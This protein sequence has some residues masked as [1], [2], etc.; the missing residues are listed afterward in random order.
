L[1]LGI[2]SYTWPWAVESYQQQKQG[3]IY[4]LKI[5]KQAALHDI[6]FVQLCDNLPLHEL[7]AQERDMLKR[8][9]DENHIVIQ[10]GTKR[11]TSDNLDR[12]ISIAVQFKSPFIRMVID[13]QGYH[14]EIEEIISMIKKALPSL[15]ENNIILAIENHDRFSS[16]VLTQIIEETSAESIGICL[17]TANSLGAGEGI[18]EV[19]ETL[20]PYAVNLHI[21]DIIIKRVSSKMGF[22]IEGAAA[23]QGILD[24]PW[25]VNELKKTG[26]CATAT[27]ESWSVKSDS[28][29]GTVDKEHQGVETSIQYLKKILS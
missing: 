19:V 28:F 21:K 10:A 8:T 29:Q 11:L 4:I 17:D 2:G 7:T 23:G 18:H 27:L 25:I 12:Y 1:F 13:D 22:A 26:R 20:A 5:L 3:M 9:A 14:P 15:K 16:A 24:I 6:H